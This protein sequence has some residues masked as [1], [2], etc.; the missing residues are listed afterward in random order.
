MLRIFPSNLLRSQ[1]TL[2][3]DR[4]GF[5]SGFGAESLTK[6]SDVEETFILNF[7][8]TSCRE[9]DLIRLQNLFP[10]REIKS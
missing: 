4:L 1:S 5:V 2:Y 6:R 9:I 3:T 7:L 8:Y 10:K